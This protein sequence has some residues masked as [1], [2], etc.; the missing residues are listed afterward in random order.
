M[1]YIASVEL[2]QK[3]LDHDEFDTFKDFYTNGWQKFVEYNIVDVKLVDAL[4]EKMKLIELAVTMA[5]DA[6]V[7]FND[8]F[9]QVRMWDMII[10]NDLKK[11]NIVI[12]PKQ[13][14]DKDDRYAGAYVKEPVPGVYDWVVSF[15][16]NSLYP[17]LIICLLYT[18]PSPRDR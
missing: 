1:D 6:K 7:N 14:E 18:S 15:D 16:L 10:Y 2:G 8:V 13:D 4:E 11:K 12:P 3:K 9:Y 17:H 5:F